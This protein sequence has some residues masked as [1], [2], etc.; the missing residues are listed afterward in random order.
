[1]ALD[2]YFL[3]GELALRLVF[4]VFRLPLEYSEPVLF[5]ILAF[6]VALVLWSWM[7]R[8]TWWA[9]KRIFGIA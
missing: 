7:I 1:M 4:G 6:F 2:I 3:P 5:R 8:C 9:I